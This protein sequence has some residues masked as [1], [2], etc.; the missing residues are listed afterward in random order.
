MLFVAM[1]FFVGLKTPVSVTSWL[2][3]RPHIL[4]L[5]PWQRVQP[6]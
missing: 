5:L 4:S 2:P 6:G 1:D 3:D